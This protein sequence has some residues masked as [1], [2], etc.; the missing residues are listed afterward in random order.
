LEEKI[1]VDL[2]FIISPL[3]IFTFDYFRDYMIT[4]L[5]LKRKWVKFEQNEH[6]C[7]NYAFVCCICLFK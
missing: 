3:C 6:Y 7:N 2:K 1:V 4:R 5:S